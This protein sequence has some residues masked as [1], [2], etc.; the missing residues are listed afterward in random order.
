ML[1]RRRVRVLV[2]RAVPEE[3][4]EKIRGRAGAIANEDEARTLN[5]RDV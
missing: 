2:V 3:N 5:A 4:D 1:E